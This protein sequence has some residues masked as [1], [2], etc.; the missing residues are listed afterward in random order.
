MR[1]LIIVLVLLAVATPIAAVEDAPDTT[2]HKC[3]QMVLIVDPEKVD[4]GELSVAEWLRRSAL[5]RWWRYIDAAT[6]GP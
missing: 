6:V 2:R 3:L 1:K 5:L 4:P